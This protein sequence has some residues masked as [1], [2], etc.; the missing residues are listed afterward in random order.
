MIYHFNEEKR[1]FTFNHRII[2]EPIEI[3]WAEASF[4]RPRIV[5]QSL[6]YM[7]HINVS[8]NTHHN[9]IQTW[10]AR[11]I[12]SSLAIG[13]QSKHH[14][15]A[16]YRIARLNFKVRRAK[17]NL[18]RRNK[19]LKWLALIFAS[20][21]AKGESATWS[22]MTWWKKKKKNSIRSQPEI[23]TWDLVQNQVRMRF[24]GPSQKLSKKISQADISW[25]MC[26]YAKRTWDLR[27]WYQVDIR[28]P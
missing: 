20:L 11:I 27:T 26:P 3:N 12:K 24:Y 25:E 18:V 28:C 14:R 2:F 19:L 10:H 8:R 17:Q 15:W 23:S 9:C 13:K 7:R 1:Y 5:E 22:E 4:L 21:P 6:L 16:N